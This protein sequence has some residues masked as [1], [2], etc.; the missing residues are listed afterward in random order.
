MCNGSSPDCLQS[1]AEQ[2]CILYTIR[3]F[4]EILQFNLIDSQSICSK[5]ILIQVKLH[6]DTS[7]LSFVL[8]VSNTKRQEL[9]LIMLM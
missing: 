8:V 4:S 2:Y 9:I 7:F 1:N 3:Y 6:A 5:L